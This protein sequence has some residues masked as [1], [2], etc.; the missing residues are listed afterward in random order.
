MKKI[1]IRYTYDE[2]KTLGLA[3]SAAAD[4]MILSDNSDIKL[5]GFLLARTAMRIT[6]RM[7]RDKDKFRYSFS[8]DEA[9]A[10]HVAYDTGEITSLNS[11]T[12]KLLD[13]TYNLIT[14][15]LQVVPA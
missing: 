5:K 13:R 12:V 10:F 11:W 3:I 1:T 7:L 6:A 9:L 8:A 15:K 2:L 14:D 4:R